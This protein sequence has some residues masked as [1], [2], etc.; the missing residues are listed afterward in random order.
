MTARKPKDEDEPTAADRVKAAQAE[1]QEAEAA[2]RAEDAPDVPTPEDP[3]EDRVASL[4][5]AVDALS[6]GNAVEAQRVRG[7]AL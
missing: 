1:L 4:E 6:R 5:A 3:I 7:T 2:Q